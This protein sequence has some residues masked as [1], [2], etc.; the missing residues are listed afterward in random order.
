MTDLIRKIAV[1]S[2]EKKYPKAK[3]GPAE[4][5][6]RIARNAYVDGYVSAL[7]ND[8]VGAALI[9]L[10]E[11]LESGK[12]VSRVHLIA[13]LTRH[14]ISISEDTPTEEEGE[15]ELYNDQPPGPL[16]TWNY[17]KK[18]LL[19]GRIVKSEDGWVDILVERDMRLRSL[20]H[21]FEDSASPGEIIRVRSDA[22]TIATT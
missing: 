13:L 10:S 20:S 12:P 8:N 2:S 22:L 4:F 21:P 16:T 15:E 19:K 9:D 6:A 11:A 14:G 17:S 7:E 1:T 3:H 18:G 5:F